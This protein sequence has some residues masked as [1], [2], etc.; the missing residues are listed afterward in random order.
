MNIGR[1]YFFFILGNSVFSEG[2][3]SSGGDNLEIRREPEEA[4]RE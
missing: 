1:S 4:A 3:I 2:G